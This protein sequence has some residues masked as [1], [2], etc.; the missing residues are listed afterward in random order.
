MSE[1]VACQWRFG[2]LSSHEEFMQQGH[3]GSQCGA[4]CRCACQ[5][6]PGKRHERRLGDRKLCMEVQVVDAFG[7]RA[8]EQSLS[9][10][11][12]LCCKVRRSRQ[13]PN[14]LRRAEG[15]TRRLA[16]RTASV[17]YHPQVQPANDS[18]KL[19]QQGTGPRAAACW[20]VEQARL[21]SLV[22][23]C[24]ARLAAL[25][26]TRTSTTGVEARSDREES[27][28]TS[29]SGNTLQVQTAT[30]SS[31]SPSSTYTTFPRTAPLTSPRPDLS[32]DEQR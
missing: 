31:T 15:A 21:A 24:D 11:V 5:S 13:G 12:R 23:S 2:D 20:L 14:P 27:A 26:V 18:C 25:D 6:M 28:R 16:G 19:K 4:E 30:T 10:G 8:S 29:R 22:S 7:S 9:S 3:A 32:E 17:A 1:R